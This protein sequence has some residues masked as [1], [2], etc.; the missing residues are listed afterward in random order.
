MKELKPYPFCGG[1]AIV[2]TA[3]F[4]AEKTIRFRVRCSGCTCELGWDFFSKE[5]IEYSWNRRSKNEYKTD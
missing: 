4:G 5:A 1:E 2:E 3:Q